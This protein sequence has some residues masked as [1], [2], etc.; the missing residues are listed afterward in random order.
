ME[1]TYCMIPFIQN[2]QNRENPQEQEVDYWSPVAGR[3]GGTSE[4]TANSYGILFRVVEMFWNW[5]AVVN[6]QHWNVLKITAL[7]TVKG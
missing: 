3:R 6:A 7:H 1:G 4:A 5:R 2:V